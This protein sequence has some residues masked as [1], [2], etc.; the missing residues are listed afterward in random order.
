MKTRENGKEDIAYINIGSNDLVDQAKCE[1]VPEMKG[2]NWT[3]P[4]S[5]SPPRDERE[6]G[7]TSKVF[8]VIFHPDTYRFDNN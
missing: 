4:H 1:R 2:C 5:M 3:L 6:N 7:K 8:D